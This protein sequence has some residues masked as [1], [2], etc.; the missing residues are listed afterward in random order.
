MR[1]SARPPTRHAPRP[2][3]N[4]SASN[5]LL[6]SFLPPSSQP[7]NPESPNSI[8]PKSRLRMCPSRCSNVPRFTSSALQKAC[9]SR[10]L[11]FIITPARDA[12]SQRTFFY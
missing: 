10:N 11:T 5:S 1:S 6:Y 3:Y 2:E 4:D 8:D 9:W 12:V 7:Y